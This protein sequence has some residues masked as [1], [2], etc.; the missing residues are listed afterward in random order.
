MFTARHKTNANYGNLV[1]DKV[2]KKVT[3]YFTVLLKTQNKQIKFDGHTRVT[4]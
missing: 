3:K 4:K 1:S 2:E